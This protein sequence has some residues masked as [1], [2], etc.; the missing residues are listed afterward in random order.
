MGT[1]NDPCRAMIRL[2]PRGVIIPNGPGIPGIP[3][4]PVRSGERVTAE[5]VLTMALWAGDGGG[6]LWTRR[7]G[8]VATCVRDGETGCWPRV[9]ETGCCGYGG[10][11]LEEV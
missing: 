3:C 2:L 10:P 7:L 5:G 8:E 9:G 6:D 4:P 1:P 11:R